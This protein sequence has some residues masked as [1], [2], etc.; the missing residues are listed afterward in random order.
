VYLGDS[1][2]LVPDLTTLLTNAKSLTVLNLNDVCLQGPPELFD[3][4]QKALQSHATLKDFSMKD[5]MTANQTIDMDKL[6]DAA[7]EKK[8]AAA[9]VAAATASLLVNPAASA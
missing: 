1:L 5:C 7:S 9:G 2:L 4:F 3:D 8:P 6:L